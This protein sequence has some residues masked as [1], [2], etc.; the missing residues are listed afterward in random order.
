[1]ASYPALDLQYAEASGAGVLEDLLYAELDAFEPLAIH[2]PDGG[3]WRVFFRTAALRDAARAALVSTLGDRLTLV[4]PVEVS[5]E[6]WAR[7]SQAA[8]TRIEVGGLIVA[9][10]WDVP[11]GREP[12]SG[13]RDPGPGIRGPEERGS[14][15]GARASEEARSESRGFADPGSR[16]PNPDSGSAIVIVIE[17]SMGFGTGHHAT[18]RLCLELLQEID[19]AGKRVIDVG[20]GSGVLALAAWRLDAPS[21]TAIDYDPDA[22]QNARENLARNGATGAI[23]II[24]ADLSDATA[25][26]IKPADLVLANLTGAVLQRFAGVLRGLVAPSGTLVVSGFSPEELN[27]VIQALGAR[28]RRSVREGEWA[29][30]ALEL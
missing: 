1:M 28:A 12:G 30:A 15:L 25:M 21:V 10:P 22:L 29:A 17:P 3:G 4:E 11:S 16:I 27:A 14:G 26:S 6:D 23:G 7:R 8:L 9:P 19:L 18:T 2:E 24:Q 5:D 20:T 13:V